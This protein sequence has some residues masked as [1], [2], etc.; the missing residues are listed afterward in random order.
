MAWVDLGLNLIER[1]LSPT[2]MLATAR[3]FLVD[4]AGREQ[5]F[6]SSL[7]HDW[8]MGTNAY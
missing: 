1:F 7:P 3:F 5:R 8:D 2:A 6:Y 4:A